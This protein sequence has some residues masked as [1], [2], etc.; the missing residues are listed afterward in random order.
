MAPWGSGDG[1]EQEARSRLA[2]SKP[3][4]NIF[5][6]E[7]VANLPPFMMSQR[8]RNEDGA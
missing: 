5:S 4:K 7:V 2:A 8:R 1:A 3:S 6:R